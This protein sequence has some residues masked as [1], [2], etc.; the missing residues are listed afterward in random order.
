MIGIRLTNLTTDPSA[1]LHLAGRLTLMIK[2]R[3]LC[4]FCLNGMT[5]CTLIRTRSLRCPGTVQ[6]HGRLARTAGMLMTIRVSLVTQLFIPNRPVA[7]VMTPLV[8]TTPD[9]CDYSNGVRPGCRTA[10]VPLLALNL[11]FGLDI[12]PVM[13]VLVPPPPSPV[14]VPRKRL[15]ALVV[16]LTIIR[17]ECPRVFTPVKTLLA[18]IKRRAKALLLRPPTPRLVKMVG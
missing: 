5:M 12:L 8:T 14:L 10:M 4:P 15:P 13:T 11:T 3:I 6:A 2:F 17:L 18:G 9:R 16:K 7:K 1:L